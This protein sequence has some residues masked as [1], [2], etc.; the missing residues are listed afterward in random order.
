MAKFH[1]SRMLLDFSTSDAPQR[2]SAAYMA[3]QAGETVYGIHMHIKARA[4]VIQED[5][6]LHWMHTYRRI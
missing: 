4:Q 2:E 6:S 1:S 3:G 5:F